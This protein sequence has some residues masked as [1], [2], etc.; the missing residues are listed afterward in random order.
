MLYVPK[1]IQLHS[2][3]VIS[4]IE[5]TIESLDLEFV[6]VYYSLY[7]YSQAVTQNK[8]WKWEATKM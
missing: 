8:N 5:D 7:W 4:K 2:T 6:I 3:I 1:Y